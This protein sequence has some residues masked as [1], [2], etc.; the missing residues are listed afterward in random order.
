VNYY[1][2]H[3]GDYAR[4]ACHLSIMEHGA[5]TLLLDRYYTTEQGIPQDQAHRVCRARSRDERAA[6]D[7]TLAEF[8]V[9]VNGI[10]TNSRAEREIAKMRSKIEAARVNG[11]SGGRPKKN[12]TGTEEKP[13]GFLPGSDLE[14]QAKALQSPVTSQI[15]IPTPVNVR[16]DSPAA[17]DESPGTVDAAHD[18]SPQP[19]VAGAICRKL[20]QAGIADTN[21]GHPRLLALIKAGCTE[22]EFVGFVPD[23]LRSGQPF[24]YLLGCVE[25]ERKRAAAN[26]TALHRGP[27]PTKADARVAA[28]IT[29]AHRFL[30]RSAK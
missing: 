17:T 19:T 10:W 25:G 12:P 7:A 5:Y 9:L 26:A 18:P 15:Q 27:M 8:F 13:T 3:L 22:A 2:R 4:D 16:C 11:R 6:V 14:T 29:A 23:A 30:E 21:P 20:R 24:P 1:E 28:N